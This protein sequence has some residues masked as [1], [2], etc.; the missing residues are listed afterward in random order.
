LRDVTFRLEVLS[1]WT[2]DTAMKTLSVQ[3]LCISLIW[4]MAWLPVAQSRAEAMLVPL[5][6]VAAPQTDR[7]SDL[8]TIQSTL[9]SKILRAHLRDLGLTDQEVQTRLS[10]LS[11]QD[12]HQMASQIRALRPAGDALVPILIVVVLVLLI[13]YLIRRV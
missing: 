6:A 9:E 3:S 12:I 5:D 2:E 4:A 8:Q 13:V 7:A 11:D 1:K 10:R